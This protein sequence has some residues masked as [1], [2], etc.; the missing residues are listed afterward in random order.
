MSADQ[1][2]QRV[3]A[4]L[5]LYAA[6]VPQVLRSLQARRQ[7]AARRCALVGVTP[8]QWE[9]MSYIEREQ[10]LAQARRKERRSR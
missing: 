7:E 10:V 1:A 4:T 5:D 3:Q 9:A 8:E 6:V 2:S